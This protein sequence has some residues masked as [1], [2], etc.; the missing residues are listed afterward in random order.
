MKPLWRVFP[1]DP[2]SPDGAPFS[3]RYVPPPGKQTKGRFDLGTVPVLYLAETPEHAVAELLRPF[4]GQRITAA[5]LLGAGHPLPLVS[6]TLP[7]E[8]AAGIADLTDPAVLLR[9]GI[10]PDALA[11]RDR[12]RTQAISRSLHTAELLGFRW[13]SALSGDWHAIVLFLDR[14]PMAR[15]GHGEPEPLSLAHPAVL[16]AA[17]ALNISI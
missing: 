6:V 8:L 2:N 11:S 1:W 3:L 4:T 14:V 7:P 5:H 9:Y 16:D 10:S 17:H 15:L 13:W 12:V